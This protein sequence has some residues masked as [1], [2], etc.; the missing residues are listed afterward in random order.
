M[1][2]NQLKPP[3]KLLS[4]AKDFS[5]STP[6][7]QLL[8]AY[9][10][11]PSDLPDGVNLI[12]TCNHPRQKG[13]KVICEV[14]GT[15]VWK[16]TVNCLHS[17]K[18]SSLPPCRALE[19]LRCSK[20]N[21]FSQTSPLA[22]VKIHIAIPGA[23]LAMKA[24]CPD[25]LRLFF[26]FGNCSSV[27]GTK[28]AINCN[29]FVLLC[30]V[31]SKWSPKC[32]LPVP[33][34]CP[35]LT[36]G[37]LL[38]CSRIEG[39][40]CKVRCPN[41]K[42][43]DEE[44]ICLSTLEWSPLPDCRYRRQCATQKLPDKIRFL[45]PSC[46][47]SNSHHCKVGCS[48]SSRLVAV[49]D[50]ECTP[51]GEWRGLPDCKNLPILFSDSI[52]QKKRCANR[53][54]K[55]IRCEGR[56][57]IRC[58][59]SKTHKR[60]IPLCSPLPQRFE[61]SGACSRMVGSICIVHCKNGN[62]E[63]NK[64]IFCFLTGQW[65]ELPLCLQRNATC[66][67]KVSPFLSFVSNCSFVEGAKCQV[68][69]QKDYVLTGLHIITCGNDSWKYVPKCFPE[70]LSPYKALKVE[71]RFPPLLHSSLK[72]VGS[73]SPK[74]GMSCDVA[75]KDESATLRGPNATTCLSPGHW[76]DTKF[77]IGGEP[78][79][80]EPILSKYLEAIENCSD[81][82]VGS[83]CQ[84]RCR[85]R[86]DINFTMIC[87]NG[88]KWSAPPKCACP[89]PS[90][91]IGMELIEKCKNKQPSESCSVKCKHGFSMN[92][93]GIIICNDELKWTSMAF[94]T[95]I[96]CEKPEVGNML[97]FKK[98][99]MSKS[100]GDSC[101]LECRKG[102]KLLGHSKIQCTDAKHW[103]KPP[104]CACPLPILDES[105]K[106][107]HNCNEILPGQKCFLNCKDNSL[108]M[109]KRFIT[110]QKDLSWSK[111]PECEKKLC[112]NPKL[113]DG[114][115]FVEDCSSKE[116]N[117]HCNIECQEKGK[118]FGTNYIACINATHWSSQP[119]CFCPI[120]ILAIFLTAKGDCRNK[121]PGQKCHLTCKRDMTLIGDA[122]IRCQKNMT[123]TKEPICKI[124]HCEKKKLPSFLQYA[125]DCTAV[126]PGETCFLK[127]KNGGNLIGPKFITCKIGLLWTS[128]PTCSCSIPNLSEDLSTTEN[129]NNKTIGEKCHLLCKKHFSLIG[130]NFMKC[131]KN[132]QWTTPPTCKK[133]FC[134]KLKLPKI[135]AFKE[136]CSSKSPGDYCSVTCKG[137]GKIVGH[138]RVM[139]INEKK[140]TAL[141]KCSCP[142]PKAHSN[143][144][145]SEDCSNKFP[146]QRCSLKC[147]G[148]HVIYGKS[149]IICGKDTQWSS[150][151]SCQTV[152]CSFQKLPEIL[153]YAS[154]CSSKSP[155]ESCLLKCSEGGKLIGANK[156]TCLNK[157]SWSP[158]PICT[159]PVP[160]LVDNLSAIEPC[161]GKTVG[162]K[163]HLTCKSSL[164][165]IGRH[166]IICQ[167]NTRW[168]SMPRCRKIF[169][170]KP[171]IRNDL[172]LLEYCSSKKVG[173][174][175][176][177]KCKEEEITSISI[178]CIKAKGILIWT[179]SPQCACPKP[180]L[181]EGLYASED[182]SRK[183]P[184]D[185]CRLA[186]SKNLT[187]IGKGF[188]TCENST[189]WSLL[190][191]CS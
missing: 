106:T 143:L 126:S 187:L 91:K 189:K 27:S 76:T 114:L 12:G 115:T 122:F 28:C 41:G 17:K 20:S 18:W 103:T 54:D 140:W 19:L 79:C 9:L 31:N 53:R 90:L 8:R 22:C 124:I 161:Q 39:V 136:D 83:M 182:C 16:E 158:F 5:D 44:A 133:M 120:P 51:W 118:I 113:S 156:I 7:M 163:C 3:K 162:E 14:N 55:C 60:D 154:D 191:K 96:L 155:G 61:L 36:F 63:G 45:V 99:C 127:C 29:G 77:C 148:N 52:N 43:A 85:A 21:E 15:V 177:L 117:E 70:V 58:S 147:K 116:P 145:T 128:L 185:K 190:P 104:K 30:L 88:L 144:V 137:N 160:H 159:C 168:S 110:C 101:R 134:S 167:K 4:K 135:L 94:C 125:G 26:V 146:G 75:C 92:G 72:I 153:S 141:P 184:G 64:T 32:S 166:F 65:S 175:C 37:D 152:H 57:N 11:R 107:N 80:L 35:E 171:R 82:I 178:T 151:P 81:K 170:P 109:N 172:E 111:A 86:P 87:K 95:K 129:C 119:L 49:Q 69:C 181:A 78:F 186:C 47:S 97:I 100:P 25:I 164:L 84:V 2:K 1:N 48:V 142:H 38:N 56:S 62:L 50:A 24:I 66:P 150:M 174:K 180:M 89:E 6:R 34:L 68:R 102:G 73:C 40:S 71:C 105:L 93:K 108:I 59:S 176:K 121:L 138:Q 188:I 169:C 10:C 149:Y 183:V 67:R 139:C 165:L 74:G 23:N 42:L 33:S 131:Q 179:P 130:E 98:E 157:T 123:W 173:E 132:R 112:P 13:C 46:Q